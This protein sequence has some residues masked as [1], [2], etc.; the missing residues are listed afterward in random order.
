MR[1]NRLIHSLTICK[2]GM[3]YWDNTYSIIPHHPYG[4]PFNILLTY[5][6]MQQLYPSLSDCVNLLKLYRRDIAKEGK[7]FIDS[8]IYTLKAKLGFH[9]L[10]SGWTETDKIVA[11]EQ[12]QKE[13]PEFRKYVDKYAEFLRASKGIWDYAIDF[14]AD[15][16][17]G[18]DITDQLYNRLLQQSALDSHDIVRVYHIAR[19][20]TTAWWN[21]L[22]TSG[23]H[24]CLAIEGGALHKW[25]PRFYK[26]LIDVAHQHNVTVH[27]FAAG[28]KS[29]LRDIPCDTA[30]S[31]THLVGSRF[32]RVFTPGGKINMSHKILGEDHYN[33]LLPAYREQLCKMWKEE[34]GYTAQQLQSSYEIRCLI[35]IWHMNRFW[36]VPYIEREGAIP[37]FNVL[38]I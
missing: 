34:Y 15:Q 13:L 17:L 1:A 26:P 7:I 22:C 28:S 19:P 37:L 31:T 5:Y 3:M 14:D 18:S 2:P 29:F 32:G 12:A 38:E 35:N 10:D 30:D 20:N 23:Q 6:Y 33:N 9:I 36:D 27:V 16:F 21:R 8:G 24:K 25:S 4:R 11:R